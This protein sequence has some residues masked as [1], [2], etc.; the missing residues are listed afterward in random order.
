MLETLTAGGPVMVPIGLLSLLAVAVFLERL[1]ALRRSAVV[2]RAFLRTF[3]DR[4]ARDDG[5]G[6]LELCR[7]ED[8]AVARILEAALTSTDTSRTGMKER[9]EEVGRREAAELERWVPVL[10][11][12]ASVA[13]LLGLLGTVLGMI[14]T[15]QAI[16]AQG[17]AADIGHLAGGISQALVTTFAGLCVGIPAVMANRYLLARV[18]ALLLELEAAGL[19]LLDQLAGPEAS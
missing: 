2:P 11:T 4:L 6:A 18:D 17:G 13:P 12:I 1:W 9:L 7:K 8:V 10:G 19:A 14:L 5:P 15:F 3:F 16:Q